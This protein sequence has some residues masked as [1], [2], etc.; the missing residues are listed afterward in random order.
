MIV[1]PFGFLAAPAGDI[2]PVAGH[3]NYFN[4]ADPTSYPG[5]GTTVTNIF[6]KFCEP[7]I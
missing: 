5:S 1:Q 6:Y 2:E 3:Y 7:D 4:I